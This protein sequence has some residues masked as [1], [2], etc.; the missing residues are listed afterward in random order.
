[1]QVFEFDMSAANFNV[2][3]FL[4]CEDICSMHSVIQSLSSL[5]F[6]YMYMGLCEYESMHMYLFCHVLCAMKQ[7]LY[8][9]I[10][11]LEHKASV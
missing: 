7:L 5:S 11:S 2:A 10:H 8:M 4:A 1:M 9:A 6:I 3:E